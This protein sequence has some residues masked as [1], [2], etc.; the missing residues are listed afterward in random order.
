MKCSHLYPGGN[1]GPVVYKHPNGQVP[2]PDAAV[3]NLENKLVQSEASSLSD[4]GSQMG[5][6]TLG[7]TVTTVGDEKIVDFPRRPAY[8]TKGTQ[9]T[10]TANYFEVK[11]KG[12]PIFQYSIE[13][14]RTGLT[15]DDKARMAA[16]ND[17]KMPEVKG[18]Q[19]RD[20]IISAL[21]QIDQPNVVTEYKSKLVTLKPLNLPN[22]NTVQ[23]E[24][25]HNN[26][27]R[28][29]EVRFRGMTK[30][31]VTGL[32]Q[33]LE[34][35]KDPKD[36]DDQGFPKYADATDALGIVLGHRARASLNDI[37]PVGKGRFF[38]ISGTGFESMSLGQNSSKD[39]LRGYFQSMRPA[40]GRML[41][42]CN[43]TH[44]IF[45]KHGNLGQMIRDL[46]LAA[47]ERPGI[48]SDNN[49]N[50]QLRTL[51]KGL[52]KARIKVNQPD[53]QRP[54]KW[55]ISEKTFGGFACH[56]DGRARRDAPQVVQMQPNY[57]HGGPKNTK[58]LWQPA[59]QMTNAP[60][61]KW[62][63]PPPQPGE[64]VKVVD[65]YK[66]RKYYSYL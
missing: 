44:G 31:N 66:K 11:A 22:N 39:I 5:Q 37:V 38:A 40:T 19:L 3:T 7:S 14:S 27:I 47:M 35:M 4:L 46:G 48:G 52:M 8:G 21:Q 32:L 17:G 29:F 41:L 49:Y 60:P 58:F 51:S 42:N 33:W 18:R 10:L 54:G 16:K 62:F 28:T 30:P 57:Q 24:L 36:V 26:R 64:Y 43:V 63:G 13:I 1:Q 55:R 23:V 6:L 45:R 61:I 50:R 65:Y 56:T 2:Q 53:P 20:I 15:A 12:T 25:V 59:P 34:T 9:V